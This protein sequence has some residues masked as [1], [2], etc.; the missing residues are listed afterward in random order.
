[1]NG[2]AAVAFDLEAQ[3]PAG[4]ERATTLLMSH[5]A[6]HYTRFLDVARLYLSSGDVDAAARV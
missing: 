3:D 4:A 2:R 1:L 5:D 6:S